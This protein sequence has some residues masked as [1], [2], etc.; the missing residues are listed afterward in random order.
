VDSRTT[1]RLT[2]IHPPHMITLNFAPKADTKPYFL[3]YISVDEDNDDDVHVSVDDDDDDDVVHVGVDDD[4]DDDVHVSVDDDDVH[5]SDDDDDDDALVSN[6]ELEV[7][8]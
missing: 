1:N 2:E 6:T 8:R 5:V 4:D 7:A 3:L